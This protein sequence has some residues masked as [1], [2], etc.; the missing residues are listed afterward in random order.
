MPIPEKPS[1]WNFFLPIICL[2]AA[3][4]ICDV[5]MQSGVII[6][7]IF[8]FALYMFQNLMSASEF[9]DLCV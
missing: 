5:D 6:T 7:L 9:A 1:V 3:T 2:I 4:I 8:M